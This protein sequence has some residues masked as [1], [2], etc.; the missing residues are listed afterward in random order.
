MGDDI[1]TEDYAHV[2]ARLAENSSWGTQSSHFR[3]QECM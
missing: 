3:A 1:I 2:V